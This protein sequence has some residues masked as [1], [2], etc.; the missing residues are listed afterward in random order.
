MTALVGLENS[1]TS[2]F[3]GHRSGIC[4]GDIDR[5][6]D[7]DLL[8]GQWE[9]ALELYIN[10]DGVFTDEAELRGVLNP[11]APSPTNVWQSVMED[12]NGDGWLDI[13]TAVDFF[14]NHLWLNQGDGTFVD[15]AVE[16][17]TNF[18]FNDMGVAVGDYDSDGDFDLYV[19]NI[20]G[21]SRHNLLLRNESTIDTVRFD[22]IAAEVGV[23]NTGF[24]WERDDC[25]CNQAAD[26]FV[27]DQKREANEV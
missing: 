10:N 7:L 17:G 16:S 15:V 5:D 24:G 12:F 22:E 8:V 18:A 1:Q 14:E 26:Q 6:G 27:A 9:G 4:C 23:D 13:Y 2:I 11:N 25:S 21:N 20:F 3:F 19:T